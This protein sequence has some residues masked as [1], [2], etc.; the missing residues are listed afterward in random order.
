[1]AHAAAYFGRLS[2]GRIRATSAFFAR[3][4]AP[5]GVLLKENAAWRDGLGDYST[6]LDM[7]CLMLHVGFATA[8]TS[9][10]F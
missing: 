1:V 8:K 4:I 7:N 2:I 9:Q 3:P 10:F 6:S 5:S